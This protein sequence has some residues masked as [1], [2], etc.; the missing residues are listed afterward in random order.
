MQNFLQMVFDNSRDAI[1]LVDADRKYVSGTKENLRKFGFNVEKLEGRDFLESMA[2]TMPPDSCARV[3]EHLCRVLKTGEA[4]EYRATTLKGNETVALEC[5][6]LPFKNN[7]GEVVG[8]MFQVHDITNLQ[9]AINN[10]E[11]ANKAKTNFLASMSH[12]IRTPLNGIIGISQLQLQ[13]NNLSDELTETFRKVYNLGSDLLRII[14]DILDMSKIET[15]K[16]E[17]QPFEYDVPSLIHDVMQLNFIRL[18]AKELEF[19]SE[20][21]EDLPARLFGD[22]LRLKQI[23]NNLLSN[24]VKYTNA[25]SVTL[26]ISH[27]MFKDYVSIQISVK[28]TGLGIKPEDMKTLFTQYARYNIGANR[29]VEG[30]GLGLAITRQLVEMMGG[31]IEAESEYGKG[32]TF[33]VTLNQQLVKNCGTIGKSTAER[34]K[35]FSFISESRSA[36]VTPMSMSHA[37][38]LVVDDVETNLCVAE[39]F[40]KL[41]EITVETVSSG[42]AAIA[43]IEEGNVYDIIFMDHMMPR[44]DGIETTKRIRELGYSGTIVA[45][46]ANAIVGNDKMFKENGFD[47]F[48]SKPIC[49]KEMD[50]VLQR[51]RRHSRVSPS[52]IAAFSPPMD[53]AGPH[54][55]LAAS[56]AKAVLYPFCGNNLQDC[57]REDMELFFRKKNDLLIKVFLRDAEKTKKQLRG[58]MDNPKELSTIAHAIKSAL[59][60]I[61][62]NDIAELAFKLENAEPSK[63]ATQSL[64]HELITALDTLTTNLHLQKLIAACDDY[65]DE[66]AYAA[67]DALATTIPA[68][69][70]EDIREKIFLHSDFENAKLLAV[71]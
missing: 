67:L 21:S 50:E 61:D 45:L 23:L 48:L 40:L 19:K 68:A 57:C 36:K 26:S 47:D 42:F 65:D 17:L 66:A 18:S 11:N 12:E 20:I 63:D 44:L 24:A 1:I 25:G 55:R 31:K 60:N 71:S 9:Q 15:G 8:A 13:R 59:R 2:E 4:A 53:S 29:N 58:A 22:E 3:N 34:L 28:D 5:T 54:V 38:M 52:G 14:N 10:A 49:I 7:N 35:N 39:D 37:R 46:S 27:A 43:K 6:I 62:E 69:K 64:A 70:I 16:L 33:T 41:Y 30:A 32:S 51:Q 56:S